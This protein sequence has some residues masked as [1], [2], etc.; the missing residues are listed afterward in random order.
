M[1]P[2]PCAHI[3]HNPDEKAGVLINLADLIAPGRQDTQ[4]A[5]YEMRQSE[6]VLEALQHITSREVLRKKQL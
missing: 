3:T 6:V 2:R 4:R 1:I 5:H